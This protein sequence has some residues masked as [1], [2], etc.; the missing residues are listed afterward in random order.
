MKSSSQSVSFGIAFAFLLAMTGLLYVWFTVSHHAKT[1]VDYMEDIRM[2]N[3]TKRFI[4]GTA[5]IFDKSHIFRIHP[6]TV[7]AFLY[8]TV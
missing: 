8:R 2:S 7:I 1:W 4:F 5:V 6:T 3:L